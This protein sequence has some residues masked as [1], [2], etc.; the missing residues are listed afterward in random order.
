M[1][2][3]QDSYKYLCSI[4]GFCRRLPN[5]LLMDPLTHLHKSLST[6]EHRRNFLLYPGQLPQVIERFRF[7]GPNRLTA[8]F[9]SSTPGPQRT[10]LLYSRLLPQVTERFVILNRQLTFDVPFDTFQSSL[11]LKIFRR[12]EGGYFPWTHIVPWRLFKSLPWHLPND[13][14]EN[15]GLKTAGEATFLKKK[16]KKNDSSLRMIKLVVQSKTYLP[17]SRNSQLKANLSFDWRL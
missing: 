2:R 11:T 9:L 5:N 14:R 15:H 6:P 12:G 4:L 16:K 17:C 13:L 7:H 8:L 10:I 3:F 1:L